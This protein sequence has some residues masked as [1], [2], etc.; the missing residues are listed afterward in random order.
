MD[1]FSEAEL[2]YLREHDLARLA[3]ATAAGAPHVVPV[4]IHLGV[5]LGGDRA[6]GNGSPD[7]ERPLVIGVGSL[8][9]PGGPRHRLYRQHVEEN[10]QLALVVDDFTPDGPRGVAVHGIGRV[11]PDGG[12]RL[13]NR[14][15]PVWL[16]IVP[17]WISSWGI[18][19][20]PMDPP[21]SR[22]VRSPAAARDGARPAPAAPR[23]GTTR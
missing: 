19:T 16:A 14:F 17:T 21:H 11:H 15:E 22:H 12:D 23:A 4:R 20:P 5:Q 13:D 18:D 7:G 3:T 6:G 8:R 2:A 1:G 9:L 10:D